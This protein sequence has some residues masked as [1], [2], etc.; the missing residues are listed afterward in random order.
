MLEAIWSAN[1]APVEVVCSPYVA[2]FATGSIAGRERCRGGEVGLARGLPTTDFLAGVRIGDLAPTIPA[3]LA[4][5]LHQYDSYSGLGPMSSQSKCVELFSKSSG[6][7]GC[8]DRSS[9]SRH[10]F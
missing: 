7:P 3:E 8:G 9:G 6:L 10:M 5:L 1:V 4:E 2:C